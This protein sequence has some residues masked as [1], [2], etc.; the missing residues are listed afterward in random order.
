VE[1]VNMDE[2]AEIGAIA[3]KK[4]VKEEHFPAAFDIK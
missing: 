4:Q 1:S 3:A 2:L